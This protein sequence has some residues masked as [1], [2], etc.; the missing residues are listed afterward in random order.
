MKSKIEDMRE[1][2]Q[3]K[4]FKKILVCLVF[5]II[6]TCYFFFISGLTPSENKFLFRYFQAKHIQKIMP[7]YK[8][9]IDDSEKLEAHYQ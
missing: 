1:F 6:F 9:L 5:C 8:I 4:Q 7:D 3:S 2:L